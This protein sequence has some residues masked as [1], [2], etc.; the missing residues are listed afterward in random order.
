MKYASLSGYLFTCILWALTA[1]S[2]KDATVDPAATAEENLVLA[3]TGSNGLTA[4]DGSTG[5]IKWQISDAGQYALDAKTLFINVSKITHLQAFDDTTGL[6]A[7]EDTTKNLSVISAATGHISSAVKSELKPGYMVGCCG[8]LQI[9]ELLKVSDGV[10]YMG[11][12]EVDFGITFRYRL[13]A[14]DAK[15]GKLKWKSGIEIVSPATLHTSED[16]IYAA[17]INGSFILDS[18]TGQILREHPSAHIPVVTDNYYLLYTEE[19]LS[20]MDKKT[21]LVKWTYPTGQYMVNPPSVADGLVYFADKNKKLLALDLETGVK[22][23]EYLIENSDQLSSSAQVMNGIL[24]VSNPNGRVYALDAL[25]GTKKWQVWVGDGLYMPPGELIAKN[26]RLYVSVN[27]KKLLA[28][29][30]QTGQ[31]VW[32]VSFSKD[33]GNLLTSFKVFGANEI[34][35]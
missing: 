30:P 35:F 17:S 25:T 13:F 11:L 4:I 8:T 24:Y 34:D 5:A 9:N 15:T 1:C 33:P 2:Q 19:S 20:A 14:S 21:G 27:Y 10:A 32:E 31:K 12:R 6:Y 26:N 28:L 18:K 3:K 22:K 29:D 7:R 23:W 16:K